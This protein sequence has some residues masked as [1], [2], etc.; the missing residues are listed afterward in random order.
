MIK[1][2]K[3][4]NYI[5]FGMSVLVTLCVQI[6]PYIHFHHTHDGHDLQINMSSHPVTQEDE[7]HSA[8]HNGDHHHEGNE[9]FVGDWNY[10]KTI[11]SLHIK[12]FAN[13]EWIAN[14]FLDE[15]R[16]PV[17]I[18][19]KASPHPPPKKIS[20]SPDLS[21]GPPAILS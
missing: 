17:S 4:S 6:F 10:I 2:I 13:L 19:H 16:K 21:R 15:N 11:S 5:I 9:H 3:K 1:L 14:G 7:H 18:S 20:Y 8:P 12:L